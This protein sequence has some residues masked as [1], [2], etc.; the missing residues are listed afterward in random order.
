MK[1]DAV[2]EYFE[3]QNRERANRLWGNVSKQIGE[4]QP[5]PI[6]INAVKADQGKDQPAQEQDSGADS[7]RTAAAL[8]ELSSTIGSAFIDD[9]F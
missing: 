4:R 2:N 3:R 9:S 1:T 5:E 6:R 7:A 8:H